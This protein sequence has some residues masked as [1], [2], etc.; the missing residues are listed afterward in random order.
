MMIV[1]GGSFDPPHLG[2]FSIVEKLIQSFP[3]PKKILIIPN[4]ISP[5]K[6]KKLLDIDDIWK[7]S[8][9]TF[10]SLLSDS[11]ELVDMEIR[12]KSSSYTY[13]TILKLTEKYPNEPFY[14]CVG[15]DSLI[16]LMQWYQFEN[17]N[18]LIHSYIILRRTTEAPHL[19]SFPN[20]EIENKSIVMD[21]PIW[22]VSS[23][24][25]RNERNLEYAK[26]W[27]NP[28]AFEFLKERGWFQTGQ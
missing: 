7:L 22:G 16:G 15:E 6:D 21:N 24:K 12:S 8:E 20:Q 18:L 5:F 25:I 19:L 2:H 9:L 10:S 17:L 14:L 28:D 23:S 26:Q 3:D 11:V 27:M 4:H 1:Y 13:D